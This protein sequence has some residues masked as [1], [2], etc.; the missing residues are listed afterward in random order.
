MTDNSNVKTTRVRPVNRTYEDR[1]GYVRNNL[2]ALCNPNPYFG[3]KSV[4]FSGTIVF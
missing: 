3:H 2:C 4:L 1:R